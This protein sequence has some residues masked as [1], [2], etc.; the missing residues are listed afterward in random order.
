MSE[1]RGSPVPGP[2]EVDD[3]L[4]R[5]EEVLLELPFE[6]ALPDLDDL[7]ARARVPAELLRRDERARKLLHEAILARPFAS[8]DA[9]QQVRTEVELL[10]LEVEVLADRL[11]R[12]GLDGTD[13]QRAVA[14][15]AEVRRRLD[16]VR[17]EL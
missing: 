7:L 2:S 1:D 14:R 4:V 11:G 13:R 15:L 17:A 16:E 5:L 3:A 12:V 9:V 10:T 6:R 8:L